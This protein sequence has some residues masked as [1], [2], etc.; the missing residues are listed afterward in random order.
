VIAFTPGDRVTCADGRTGTVK[1][2]EWGGVYVD[3]DATETQ[4]RELRVDR[5][6]T[7]EQER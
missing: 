3:L 5:E 7:L 6:S 4:G 1:R 2:V